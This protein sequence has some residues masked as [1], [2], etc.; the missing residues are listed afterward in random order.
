MSKLWCCFLCKW[1]T[2]LL[3]ALYTWVRKM[4]I[5]LRSWWIKKVGQQDTSRSLLSHWGGEGLTEKFK[6]SRGQLRILSSSNISQGQT[7]YQTPQFEDIKGFLVLMV[8][9]THHMD[10]VGCVETIGNVFFI[11][12]LEE[13]GE[14]KIWPMPRRSVQSCTDLDPLN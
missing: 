9:G 4:A 3:L 12:A 14:R 8:C 10:V 11:W 13:G 2:G 6:Y 1:E 5:E 7:M